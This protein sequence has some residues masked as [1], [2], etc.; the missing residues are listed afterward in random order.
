VLGEFQIHLEMFGYCKTGQLPGHI[1]RAHRYFEQQLKD[2]PWY[3]EHK[4]KYMAVMFEGEQAETEEDTNLDQ[5]MEK[6]Y[7]R[8]GYR[9]LFATLVTREENIRV[10]R[11]RGL[12]SRLQPIPASSDI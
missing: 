1:E 8:W 12:S 4:G 11:P 3:S 10:V 7:K 9:P 5:L 6:A 2:D